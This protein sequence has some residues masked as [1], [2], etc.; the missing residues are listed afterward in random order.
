[1][2]FGC[3]LECPPARPEMRRPTC[4]ESSPQAQAPGLAASDVFMR[5][6]K[7][8]FDMMPSITWLSAFWII[9]Y[10]SLKQGHIGGAIDIEHLNPTPGL[11]E[12]LHLLRLVRGHETGARNADDAREQHHRRRAQPA[13]NLA[14][15]RLNPSEDCFGTFSATDGH[16]RRNVDQVLRAHILAECPI[17]RPLFQSKRRCITDGGIDVDLHRAVRDNVVR[18]HELV[19]HR[20][21]ALRFHDDA[22]HRPPD[23]GRQD[24]AIVGSR[25]EGLEALLRLGGHC[26]IFVAILCD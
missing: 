10:N 6:T 12:G 23:V 18:R 2:P 16:T 4:L 26:G 15:L 25:N 13:V 9:L 20:V 22:E 21:R 3:G 7:P 19:E 11:P 14:I 5:P 17:Q 1:M 8:A 24:A